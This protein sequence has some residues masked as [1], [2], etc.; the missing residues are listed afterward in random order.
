VPLTEL[1][2]AH[3]VDRY[4]RERDRIDKLASTVARH[5]SSRL[6]S[7]AIPH[8]PTFRSKDPESLRLKLAR[9]RAKHDFRAF[10]REFGPSLLDLAG[11][12][13]LVYRPRDVEPTCDIIDEL[14]TVPEPPR[15]RKDY[16]A[17]AAYQARH[18]V[19]T[20]RDEQVDSDPALANLRFVPCEIQVVTIADHIW[21]E[22]EHDIKYKTPHGQPN[23]VQLAHLRNL[24]R[25]WMSCANP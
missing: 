6:R 2:I 10:D 13:I 25:S 16:T 22:L 15:F 20:L 1:Q 3:L 21:N 7:A 4:C 18:R 19:A 9:D 24:T 5:L 8:V 12:R 17:A 23:D 11:V 14:F